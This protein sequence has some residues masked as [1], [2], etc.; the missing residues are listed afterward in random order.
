MRK[1]VDKLYALIRKPI[2]MSTESILVMLMAAM[3]VGIK[4]IGIAK[5]AIITVAVLGLL[6]IVV[7]I[8]ASVFDKREV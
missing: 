3:L 6:D 5:W 2:V 1:I 8:L 4:A 7:I